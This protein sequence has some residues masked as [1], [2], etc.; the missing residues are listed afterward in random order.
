M[1]IAMD[2]KSCHTV[3]GDTI[4]VKMLS[5]FWDNPKRKNIA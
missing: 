3:A 4:G 1:P 5:G 2:I